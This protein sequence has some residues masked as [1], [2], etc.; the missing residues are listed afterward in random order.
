MTPNEIDHNFTDEAVCPHCG[1]KHNDSW[2]FFYD[3]DVNEIE[4]EADCMSCNKPMIITRHVI[5]D[6][7]TRKP[8]E[9]SEDH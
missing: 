7:C 5:V 6:Y 8:E 9:T 3:V 4:I 2:D 1:H